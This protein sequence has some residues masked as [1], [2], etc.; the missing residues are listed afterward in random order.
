MMK[1]GMIY[2]PLLQGF[3][4]F[5]MSKVPIRNGGQ[6]MPMENL[7]GDMLKK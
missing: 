6:K 3:I 4:K 1:E 7:M 5:Y 2:T